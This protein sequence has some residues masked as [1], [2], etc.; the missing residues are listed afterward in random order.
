[1]LITISRVQSSSHETLLKFF[2]FPNENL[3][4]FGFLKIPFGNLNEYLEKNHFLG[5]RLYFFNFS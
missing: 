1:M 2:K 5:K 4:C 3:N